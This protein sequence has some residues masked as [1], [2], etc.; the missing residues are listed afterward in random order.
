MDGISNKKDKEALRG[1][2][3]VTMIVFDRE[4]LGGNTRFKISQMIICGQ[5]EGIS[6]RLWS[7]SLHHPSS[8]A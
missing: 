8:D 2:E 7:S 5:P 4:R 3:V 1:M 6:D